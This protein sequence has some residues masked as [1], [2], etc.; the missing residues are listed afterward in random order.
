M[1]Q[2]SLNEPCK[3]ALVLQHSSTPYYIGKPSSGAHGN[4]GVLLNAEERSLADGTYV[5]SVQPAHACTCLKLMRQVVIAE[6]SSP[7][8]TYL[9]STAQQPLILTPSVC[10]RRSPC[11]CASVLSF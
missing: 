5:L 8:A 9:Q 2:P 1:L 6:L 11:H 3:I 7:A 4:D 10:L